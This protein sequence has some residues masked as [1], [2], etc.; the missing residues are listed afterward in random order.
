MVSKSSN[1]VSNLS[2]LIL[3][4]KKN[5]QLLY[6]IYG[7]NHHTTYS[8]WLQQLGISKFIEPLEKCNKKSLNIS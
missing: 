6:I 7:K 2:T 3:K 5:H 4:D 8:I 1:L